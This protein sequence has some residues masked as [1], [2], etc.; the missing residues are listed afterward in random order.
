METQH[1]LRL[2]EAT[3]AKWQALH[4]DRAAETMTRAEYLEAQAL[5]AQEEADGS[6]GQ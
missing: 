4:P 3:L 2:V 5:V 1:D 6:S